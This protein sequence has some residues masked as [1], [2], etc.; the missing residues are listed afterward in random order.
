MKKIYLFL[1][2]ILSFGNVH[3]Q[4]NFDVND[5]IGFEQCK[6]FILPKNESHANFELVN[7]LIDG[8]LDSISYKGHTHFPDTFIDSLRANMKNS[9]KSRILFHLNIKEN[10]TLELICNTIGLIERSFND[11]EI[12]THF[13]KVNIIYE[14]QN[15]D[16]NDD[17]RSQSHLK[18]NANKKIWLNGKSIKLNE[19]ENQLLIQMPAHLILDAN[20]KL[21]IEDLVQIMEIT[22]KLKIKTILNT[23][24]RTS[25]K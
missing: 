21:L 1:V 25:K 24:S 5:S 8:N 19:L 15:S 20:P 17:F 14:H 23:P 18:I 3:S 13:Y 4:N 9:Q 10:F 11:Y 22:K 7:I 2:L 6:K 16:K 12:G